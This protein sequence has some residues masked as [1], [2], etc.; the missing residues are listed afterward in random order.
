VSAVDEAL[1]AN[2][3]YSWLF[4]TGGLAAPPE[5]RLAVLTCMDAR[6]DVLPALGLRVGQAHVLRNAGALVTDD[7]V[8]SL[9]LSQRRLGTREVLVMAHTGCGLEGLDEAALLHEV[10]AATGQRPALGFGAFADLD[11]VVR[12]GV[13]RLRSTPALPHRDAVRGA[14][15]DLATGRVREVA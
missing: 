5:Q 11:Q 6:I 2:R 10:T 8:R 12:T 7:V 1:A 13:D 15:F 14:V 3:T 4:S 9:V